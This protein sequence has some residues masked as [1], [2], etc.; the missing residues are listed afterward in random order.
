MRTLVLFLAISLLVGSR[1]AW[2]ADVSW[3][4]VVLPDT[5]H[6]KTAATWP[7]FNQMTQW[8]VDEK[9]TRSIQL[10]LHEGD[11]TNDSTD[12]QWTEAFGAMSRL[13]GEVP[14]IVVKGNHDTSLKL[15]EYFH[16]EDNPLNNSAAGIFT[17]QM[18]PGEMDNVYGTFTAPDGRKM[19]VFG[20]QFSPT[21]AIRAWANSI[22]AQSQYQDYTAVVLT[23]AYLRE[24]GATPDGEPTA[25]RETI[26]NSLWDG[27][28]QMHG[29][30]E[31]VLNGHAHDGDDTNPHGP[32][33]T[34]RQV[35]TGINGNTVYEIVFNTQQL[36]SGGNGFLRLMEFLDDGTTV[37]VRT[38]S[39]YLDTWL[40]GDRHE[41]QIQLSPLPNV[42]ILPGDYNA[43]GVVD[44]ADYTVWRNHLGEAD[45][46]SINYNGD[47]DG[48]SL[49]DF[50]MWS[51]HYGDSA[52]GSGIDP[53]AVPEPSAF[54]MLLAVAV[55][56]WMHRHSKQLSRG[57]VTGCQGLAS[58]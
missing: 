16:L 34:A 5:Q 18:V 36:P 1:P 14:Y 50:A 31:M 42:P 53:M 49:S 3:S 41:F 44:A 47:G 32:M 25:Y 21:S 8:I 37:Q 43:D 9:D 40:T 51:Q 39:P 30:I 23:H 19:L 22:A 11:I 46:A 26:G 12:L 52:T 35:S 13:N 57:K 20:L 17:T 55:S 45:E 15:N 58:G 48:V 33:A 24:G 54:T 27:L 38:Y 28:V 2:S 4:M 29:N 7:I 6:Y 10:V 56:C